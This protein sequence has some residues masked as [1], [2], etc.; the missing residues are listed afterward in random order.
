M[1]EIQSYYLKSNFDLG[2]WG[3]G[4]MYYYYGHESYAGS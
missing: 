3:R 4:N 1:L 2:G